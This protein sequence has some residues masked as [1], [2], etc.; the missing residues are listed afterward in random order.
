MLTVNHAFRSVS[1]NGK[2][3]YTLKTECAKPNWRVR[4]AE[5]WRSAVH[6]ARRGTIHVSPDGITA[7]VFQ[8]DG[9]ARTTSLDWKEVNGVVA[10]KR[11]LINVDLIRIGFAT[12]NGTLEIDEE[13]EGWNELVDTLPARL[14]GTR[15]RADWWDEV[16][17]PAFAAN[18]TVLFSAR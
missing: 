6:G 15:S 5:R 11:D 7:T 18:P 1:R 3:A 13:M 8:Y 10:Y 4:V 12:A 17:H 9:S 16:A 14:P 2:G